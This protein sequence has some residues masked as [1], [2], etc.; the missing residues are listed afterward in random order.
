MK[1]SISENAYVFTAFFCLVYLSACEHKPANIEPDPIDNF[2]AE[3]SKILIQKCATAGCHN[4]TSFRNAGGLLLDSWEHLFNGGNSGAVVV[5]FNTDYSPLLYLINTDSTLGVVA[6]PAMPYNAPPLS[7]EEY[8]TIKNWIE[9]GAPDKNGKI[10]FASLPATRQKIYM[11]H[12]SCDMV[13]VIDAEKNVVMRY[14]PIGEEA[15]PESPSYVQVSPNDGR[16]VF[17]SFWYNQ[18]MYKID[19]YTDSVIATIDLGDSFWSILHISQDGQKIVVTNGDSYNMLLINT[20][21]LQTQILP[22]TDFINPHGIASNSSFDTFY[23]TSQFGNTVYKY[24]NGHSKK[25]SVD[26]QPLITSSSATTPDPHEIVMAPDYSK[27]FISCEQSHEIRIM[28]AHSD[29]LIKVIPVGLQP[30]S[31]ALSKNQ[32]YLFVTCMEENTAV[33]GY[34]GSVYVINYITLEIVKEI[35]SDFYQP[36]AL[37]IN[38][39]DNTLYIFSRNQNYGGPTPHHQGPCSGRNGYYCIYDINTLIPVSHKRHEVL[40]DPFISDVRFK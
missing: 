20:V 3:I 11:V 24:A 28:D 14:I 1:I 15:Y 17:V 7:R 30:Q 34:K 6:G 29:T 12:Q 18:K 4:S 19:T 23:V 35:E 8:L 9:K 31:L 5:P 21:S 13:A 38:N 2:P 16:Y 26:K 10:P 39:R 36:H 32:P 27:Y 22:N 33:K 25:I 40:V 37:S